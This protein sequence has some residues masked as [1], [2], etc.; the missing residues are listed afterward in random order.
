MLKLRSLAEQYRKQV[1]ITYTPEYFIDADG[2]K[3][4]DEKRLYVG[5]TLDELIQNFNYF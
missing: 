2:Y 4:R 1:K 3:I 5:K